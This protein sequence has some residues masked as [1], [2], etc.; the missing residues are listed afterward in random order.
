M[1]LAL[2]DNNE[3]AGAS[4]RQINNLPQSVVQV[5]ISFISDDLNE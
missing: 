1:L 4:Q 3:Q 2:D 5:Y